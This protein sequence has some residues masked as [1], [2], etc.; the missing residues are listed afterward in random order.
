MTR[1][2][3]TLSVG[4]TLASIPIRPRQRADN[5]LDNIGNRHG[6]T[7]G[8]VRYHDASPGIEEH[9]SDERV[10]GFVQGAPIP[11]VDE[12][13]DWRRGFSR[14]QKYVKRLVGRISIRNVQ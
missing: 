10:V 14:R 11:A 7:H 3:N 4:A 8:I 6:E 12:K 2:G 5:L 1:D 9:W 13:E